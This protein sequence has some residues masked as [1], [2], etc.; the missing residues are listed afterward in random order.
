MFM[1]AYTYYQKPD[2]NLDTA[3]YINVLFVEVMNILMTWN[4][5]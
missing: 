4:R 1:C 3:V 5:L 2:Y